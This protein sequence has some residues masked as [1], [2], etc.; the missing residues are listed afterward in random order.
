MVWRSKREA[1]SQPYQAM[2]PRKSTMGTA[3]TAFSSQRRRG[4]SSEGT[5]SSA[6]NSPFEKAKPSTRKVC[7]ISR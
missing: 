5:N 2:S 3:I 1:K 6:T 7:Q 4:L